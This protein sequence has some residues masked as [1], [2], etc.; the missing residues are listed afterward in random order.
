MESDDDKGEDGETLTA[1]VAHMA[2]AAPPPRTM[3]EL[4]QQGTPGWW[5]APIGRHIALPA[6]LKAKSLSPCKMREQGKILLEKLRS[7]RQAKCPRF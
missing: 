3:K 2:A 5:R 1:R 4:V 6:K 7:Q